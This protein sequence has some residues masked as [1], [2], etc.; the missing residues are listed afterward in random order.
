[1]RKKRYAGMLA[2]VFFALLPAVLASGCGKSENGQE[3]TGL[4]IEKNG[5]VT[6]C[7][8]E[9]FDKTYY[10]LEGL[11]AMIR[12]EIAAYDPSGSGAVTL[13]SAE[14]PEEETG[15]VIV[16]MKY[17]SVEDYAKFNETVLFYGTVAQAQEAGYKF[18]EK[19]VSV[20]D[21]TKTLAGTDLT[22]MADSPVLITGEALQ[23]MLPAKVIYISD[24]AELVNSKCVN[25]V[26]TDGLTYVIMK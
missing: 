16:T 24:G 25:A 1:M 4:R 15:K 13:Q 5:G 12:E 17:A 9:S 18:D 23:V 10:S 22:A 3:T 6:S 14:V 2:A 11:E 8:V 19:L 26:N 21:K 20:S 7:I